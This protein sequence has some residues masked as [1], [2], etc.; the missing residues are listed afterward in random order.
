MCSAQGA[1]FD[2]GQQ[3]VKVAHPQIASG[4][5]ALGWFS[6]QSVRDDA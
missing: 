4:V 3:G 2:V 1:A 6:Q 5:S